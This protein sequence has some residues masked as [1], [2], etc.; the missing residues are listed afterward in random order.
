MEKININKMTLNMLAVAGMMREKILQKNQELSILELKTL[1]IVSNM[2]GI[3]MG[4]LARC[5]HIS[6]PSSTEITNKLI[7]EGSLKRYTNKKD[8]RV[9]SLQMTA[10]GKKNLDKSLVLA[11]ANIKDML[12][13]LSDEEK[14]NFNTILEKIINKQKQNEL[15][16]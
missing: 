15:T 14:K 11:G 3:S 5:L 1:G 10:L 6:A 7:K 2:Q 9:I 4:D 8:R 12:S 13:S 16:A